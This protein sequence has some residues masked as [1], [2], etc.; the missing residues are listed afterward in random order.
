MIKTKNYAVKFAFLFSAATALLFGAFLYEYGRLVREV[1]EAKTEA[2]LYVQARKIV[3]EMD[4]FDSRTEEYFYFPR[5]KLYRAALIDKSG[6]TIFSTLDF[7]PLTTRGYHKFNERRYLVYELPHGVYFGADYLVVSKD[8]YE[9]EIYFRLLVLLLIVVSILFGVYLYLIRLFERPL[10]KMNENLDRFIK[11]SIHE[12]NTPLA[13]ISTNVELFCMK[14]GE[15]KHLARI[16]AAA[17][18]LSNLYNDMEYLIKEGGGHF[19]KEPTNL[20]DAVRQRVEYFTEIADMKGISFLADI[21]EECIVSVNPVKLYRL[22]DNNLS[23][24]IKYSHENSKIEV[25]L[26]K[27]SDSQA[28]LCFKDYGVG[29]EK[30][31]KIFDRYYREELSKGGFGL[32]L[33]IVKNICDDEEITIEVFSKVDEGSEFRYYF[34]LISKKST[35]SSINLSYSNKYDTMQEKN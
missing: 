23:N 35:R 1:Q 33:S 17:K 4:R 10:L 5:Y 31:D 34:K 30:P 12:I 25:S 21:C 8:F 18:S 3:L 26:K 24:A 7:N 32:G 11:D 20:G 15:S 9:S 16:K 19:A 2:E 6:K 27:I 22:I 28:Q 29:I 14:H 13:I